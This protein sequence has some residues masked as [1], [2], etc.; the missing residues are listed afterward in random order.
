VIIETARLRLRPI[1]A[2]DV[3]AVYALRRDLR[4]TRYLNHAPF[5]E[6]RQAEERVA[7]LMNEPDGLV[8]AIA[9]PAD[10]VLLGTV[11]LF[12]FVR[13]HKRCEL[14][15]ELS[16]A[17][18]GRGYAL[19][20]VRAALV[21]AFS[22][23]GMERIEADVDPRNTPSRRLVE[24]LGFVLEGTLRARWYVNGEICDAS[25]YGLLRRDF[26]A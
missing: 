10:D 23:E 25:F 18:Q 2:D 16:P 6:R 1:R 8:W 4:V 11:S 26:V 20:A 3:D 14:G 24:R 13:D 15:Y 9:L 12:A 19:E 7:R 17:A 21:H 22:V 5:T